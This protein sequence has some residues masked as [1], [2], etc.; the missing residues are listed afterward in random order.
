MAPR[1]RPPQTLWAYAYQ[2]VP[3]P[4][5]SRL[6]AVRALLE[7]EHSTSRRRSRAWTGRLIAGARQT[8]I[9]I[10]SDSLE[11]SR[12]VNRRL[13]AE[14]KRLKVAFS[15]TEPLTLACDLGR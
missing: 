8:R 5:K 1:S 12:A 6:R 13:E 2:I 15:V 4:T 9:L 14:L 7:K 11:R 10:V 3:P